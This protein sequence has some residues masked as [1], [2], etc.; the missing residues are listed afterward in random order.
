M[1]QPLPPPNT[2]F[3]SVSMDF[4]THLPNSDGYDGIFSIVDRFSK[5]VKFIPIKGTADA[6]LIA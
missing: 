3:E 2:C 6:P 1:L 5:Y 4:I